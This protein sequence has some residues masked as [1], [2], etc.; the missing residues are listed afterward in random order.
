MIVDCFCV[1]YTTTFT[2]EIIYFK[3]EKIEKKMK[4]INK[5]HIK[6]KLWMLIINKEIYLSQSTH[7][8]H[9]YLK[10]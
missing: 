5:I 10:I 2:N 4:F 7:T 1:L 8:L 3:G 6:V 9:I